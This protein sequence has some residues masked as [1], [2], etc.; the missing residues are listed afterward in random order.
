MIE[1]LGFFP[2]AEP[3]T[4]GAMFDVQNIIPYEA[5]MKAAGALRARCELAP[6]S[7]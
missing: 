3:Q 2:D 7:A 4:Q 5:G 6:A 1:L